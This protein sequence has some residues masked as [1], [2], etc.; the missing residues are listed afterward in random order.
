M[1]QGNQDLVG[2]QLYGIR[3]ESATLRARLKGLPLEQRLRVPSISL[4]YD[5]GT[6]LVEEGMA[7]GEESKVRLGMERIDEAN[8]QLGELDR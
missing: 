2:E 6:R 8:R 5:E 4:I 3:Q 1:H 7:S